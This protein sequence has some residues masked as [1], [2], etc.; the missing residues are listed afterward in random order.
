MR[1]RQATYEASKR[2]R[3]ERNGAT[4]AEPGA[5]FRLP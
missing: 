5:D 4:A 2:F 3:A 1:A